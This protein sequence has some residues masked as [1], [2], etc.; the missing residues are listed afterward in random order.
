[1]DSSDEFEDGDPF[2]VAPSSPIDRGW[3]SS[4]KCH[5]TSPDLFFPD[6]SYEDEDGGYINV[7][8]VATTRWAKAFCWGELDGEE[9]PVRVV[10][11]IQAILVGEKHGV[12]GGFSERERRLIKQLAYATGWSIVD[13]FVRETITSVASAPERI[14]T[15]RDK[16]ARRRRATRVNPPRR[17]TG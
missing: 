2:V 6:S 1:M 4:A 15:S 10:C 12:W 17:S 11:G 9:C 7:H 5:N 3:Y 16:V 13:V 14:H 8:D